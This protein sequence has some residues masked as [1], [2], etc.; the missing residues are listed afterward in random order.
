MKKLFTEQE[1]PN[2]YASLSETQPG[3]VPEELTGDDFP[4]WL[5]WQPKPLKR[6]LEYK[7]I[8]P[9]VDN[10]WSKRDELLTFT[11]VEEISGDVP[12]TGFGIRY[13][14]S[15]SYLCV[16]IDEPTEENEELVKLL[17]SYTEVSPSGSGCHVLLKCLDKSKLEKCFGR[18]LQLTDSGRDLFV[19]VGYVTVTGILREGSPASITEYTMEDLQ[20]ILK[21]FFPQRVKTDAEIFESSVSEVPKYQPLSVTKARDLL[22]QVPVTSLKEDT[23]SRLMSGEQVIL[24]HSGKDEA[25]SP[26]L[27]VGQALHHN[28]KG[29]IEGFLVWDEWSKQ[30]PKYDKTVCEQKW[31]GFKDTSTPVTVGV[32]IKLVN[33]QR[34]KFPD[35][36]AKGTHL[37]TINNFTTYLEFY[38]FSCYYN[39]ITKE[40]KVEVPAKV[41]RRWRMENLAE[42]YGL[43]LS[44]ISEYII[45]DLL[46]MGFPPSAF[47][48]G[49]VKKFL[50]A[51]CKTRIT[52]PI[53]EYFEECGENWDGEDRLTTLYDTLFPPTSHQHYK[54]VAYNHFIR[55]WLIQV[56]AAACHDSSRPVRLNRVLVFVGPQD[57]GKTKWIESL[58]PKDLQ[59]HC[60]SKRLN[61]GSF[62]SDDVKLTMELS[63]MLI[64]NLNEVD[65]YFSKR[66]SSE[67][68]EFLDRTMDRVVLPYGE[69]ATKVSRRTVFAG[70]ANKTTF[71]RDLTGNRRYELIHVEKILHGHK[72]SIDQLWG[73]LYSIYE[74]GE[75]WWFDKESPEDLPVI[76]ARDEINNSALTVGSEAV[77]EKLYYAFDVE[78]ASL[79]GDWRPMVLKDI[80]IILG[81]DSMVVNSKAFTELKHSVHVWSK[82]VSG[83]EPKRGTGVRP[84]VYY[85]MP[86]LRVDQD[87]IPDEGF[88]D[89]APT[90]SREDVLKRRILEMEM[91][92]KGLT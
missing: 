52:N 87:S 4:H 22:R 74:S 55:R 31:L 46:T 21:D 80:R 39:E 47:G 10:G 35:V 20:E 92:L 86:P 36:N 83:R 41:L 90:E 79:T 23:F 50:S 32:I 14:L 53:K 89:E 58:F 30:G 2:A 49:K 68:K 13:D 66:G 54:E 6:G 17:N 69:S 27:M 44:E 57:V 12:N 64:C 37:G 43:T 40:P 67:F 26:W 78:K 19:S 91:E 16:D 71:L 62:R 15:H 1:L 34:P 85:Y 60:A 84:L 72:I 9:P 33:A 28:F 70:S 45:T 61:F 73:Q 65:T 88:L 42:G 5:L 38:G 81:Y 82:Q 77:A 25:Y 29:S 63:G 59:E 8:K 75:R 56:V 76:Q 48:S 11:E 24:D 18:S 3:G 7:I 51:Q